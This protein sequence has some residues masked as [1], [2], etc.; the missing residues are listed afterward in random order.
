MGDILTRLARNRPVVVVTED[1]PQN[2]LREPPEFAGQY[3]PARLVR[4]LH[5]EADARADRPRAFGARS[6]RT[7]RSS[8]PTRAA[9]GKELDALDAWIKQQIETLPKPQRVLVTAHDAFGYFGRRYGMEVV[10]HPG[11][12]HPLRGRAPRRGPGGPDRGGPQGEGDLR[13]IERA[14]AVDR[15][16]AGGG[17][18][19]AATR[20]RS[21]A[22][23]SPTPW[24]P[25]ARP[26][27][28][29][30]AWSGPTSTPSSTP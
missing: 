27:A 26:R 11:D 29:T 6:R 15:G 16:R 25:P 17:A 30:R 21:A 7:P 5:V 14:A 24:A 9:Y 23:S 10:G 2:L 3:D 18:R 22:S 19:R 28:P 20:R 13:R 1:I 8:R 4:R 12:Q